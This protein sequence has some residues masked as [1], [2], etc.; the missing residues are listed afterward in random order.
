M[1]KKMR[2]YQRCGVPHDWLI[3]PI[4]ETLVVYHWT[5]SG[6]LLALSAERE[7][8]V[9]AEPFDAVT[10]SVHGLLEGDDDEDD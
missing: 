4:Q 9:R 5:E 8:R 7:E 6:Y 10:L 2:T 1:L 3:D